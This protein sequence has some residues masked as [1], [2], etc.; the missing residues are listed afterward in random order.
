MK[1]VLYI[2]LFIGFI[3]YPIFFGNSI[4]CDKQQNMCVVKSL[5]T[6]KIIDNFNYNNIY[7]LS[8]ESRGRNYSLI[9]S[10]ETTIADGIYKN[11]KEYNTIEFSSKY[12]CEHAK[13]K[14]LQYKNSNDNKFNFRGFHSFLLELLIFVILLISII[15]LKDNIIFKKYK[16]NK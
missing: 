4:S 15:W 13:N 10:E 5:F 1:K 3:M 11:G 8:C 9:F 7:L 14:F 2:L 12:F 16:N 6:N